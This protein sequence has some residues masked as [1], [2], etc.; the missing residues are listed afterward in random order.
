MPEIPQKQDELR[1]MMDIVK[2]LDMMSDDEKR[3]TMTFLVDRYSRFIPTNTEPQSALRERSAG[4]NDGA[5]LRNRVHP[6]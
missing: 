2:K 6:G 3:R 1:A 4:N 5:G